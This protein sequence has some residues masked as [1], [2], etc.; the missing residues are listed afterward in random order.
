M[1]SAAVNVFIRDT[2]YVVESA[3]LVLFWLV[4]VIYSSDIIPKRYLPIYNL[5]PV[6]A[7]VVA[8]RQ[9]LL[10]GEAPAAITLVNLVTVSICVFAIGLVFFRR[11][12]PNFYEHI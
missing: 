3:N 1:F 11:M 8:L 2:R 7:L 4:P 12:M 6:A 10:N 5:N 9:I